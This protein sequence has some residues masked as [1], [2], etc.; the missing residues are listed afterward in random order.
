M[1][2]LLCEIEPGGRTWRCLEDQMVVDAL[3]NEIEEWIVPAPRCLELLQLIDVISMFQE[4][5]KEMHRSVV[6]R[7]EGRST[8]RKCKGAEM[9]QMGWG[10]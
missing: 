2:F 8:T 1:S 3:A 4:K 10:Y 7:G 5:W 9:E 6:L